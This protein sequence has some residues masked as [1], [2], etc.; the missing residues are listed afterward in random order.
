MQG[1]EERTGD[2]SRERDT[3]NKN[4]QSLTGWLSVAQRD[5]A[6]GEEEDRHTIERTSCYIT[7]HTRISLLNCVVDRE[8]DSW[9]EGGRLDRR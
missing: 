9:D 2:L 8:R 7:K 6:G 5:L 4:V 1:K 3:I